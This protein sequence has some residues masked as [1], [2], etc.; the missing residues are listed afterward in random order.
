MS[1]EIEN[2]EVSAKTPQPDIMDAYKRAMEGFPPEPKAVVTEGYH[3]I[4][5]TVIDRFRATHLVTAKVNRCAN[6]N[7]AD[8][9]TLYCHTCKDFAPCAHIMLVRKKEWGG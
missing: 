6:P 1:E 4:H 9:S 7:Q 2:P 5:W 8:Q 3:Y